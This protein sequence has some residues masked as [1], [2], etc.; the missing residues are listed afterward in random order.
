[1]L[2]AVLQERDTGQRVE[3]KIDA[4]LLRLWERTGGRIKR[5]LSTP[6]LHRLACNLLTV[7]TA[8]CTEQ[9]GTHTLRTHTLSLSV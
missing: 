8:I 5:R 1:M 7:F 4:V 2:C 9:S 6:A 3:V